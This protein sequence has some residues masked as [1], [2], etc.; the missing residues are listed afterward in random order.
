MGERRKEDIWG[1]R[2][3]SN[4]TV[5]GWKRGRTPLGTVTCSL[6]AHALLLV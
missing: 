2:K 4:T 6:R 1:G 5:F 3:I